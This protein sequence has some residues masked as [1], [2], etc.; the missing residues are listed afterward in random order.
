MVELQAT[1]RH[2]PTGCATTSPTTAP[3]HGHP[4][5]H[6]RDDDPTWVRTGWPPKV[7]TIPPIRQSVRVGWPAVELLDPTADPAILLQVTL[8]DFEAATQVQD[9]GRGIGYLVVVDAAAIGGPWEMRDN[10]A[11]AAQLIDELAALGIQA[12]PDRA[13][14]PQNLCLSLDAVA[15]LL[16]RVRTL[17]P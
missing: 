9:P 5:P 12:L 8:A 16:G 11:I 13:S 15:D 7:L 2:P 14:V 3:R 17:K 6:L 4:T 10:D 1:R